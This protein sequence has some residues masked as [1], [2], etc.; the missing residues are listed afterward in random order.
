MIS[1]HLPPS[2]LKL[3]QL[4]GFSGDREAGLNNTNLVAKESSAFS[5]VAKLVIVSYNCFAETLFGLGP[6]DLEPV[7]NFIN[8]GMK[9]CPD[10]SSFH[11]FA[12]NLKVNS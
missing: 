10:V 11:L 12:Y 8:D 1:C 3:V 4:V 7:K 5:D 2:F 6:D 9:R